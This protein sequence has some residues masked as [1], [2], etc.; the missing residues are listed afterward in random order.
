MFYSLSRIPSPS[1][2]PALLPHFRE[3][4]LLKASVEN[5]MIR[6]PCFILF[7]EF[8]ALLHHRPSL[9]YWAGSLIQGQPIMSRPR[10]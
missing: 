9:T 3:T 2:F 7:L 5:A 8:P 4:N 10:V 6:L 1:E